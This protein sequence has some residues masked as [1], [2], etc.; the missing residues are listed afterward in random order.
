MARI[1]VPSTSKA[2]TYHENKDNTCNF[3]RFD[4]TFFTN[5]QLRGAYEDLELEHHKLK[6][7][8][9]PK[10]EEIELL[11]NQVDVLTDELQ[12][13]LRQIIFYQEEYQKIKDETSKKKQETDPINY[14]RLAV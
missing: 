3:K 6:Q 11:T 12:K 8:V 2:S 10:N 7:K 5:R 9:Q 13:A 14:L 4:L 1:G